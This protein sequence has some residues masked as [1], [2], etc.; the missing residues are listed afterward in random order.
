MT[1]QSEAVAHELDR[2]TNKAIAYSVLRNDSM[3]RFMRHY[4]AASQC[5]I[6][7]A[8][9]LDIAKQIRNRR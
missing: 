7:T 8:L 6:A 2:L 4:N 9:E 3:R 5:G 1:P